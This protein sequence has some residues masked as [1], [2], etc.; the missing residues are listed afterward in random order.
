MLSKYFKCWSQ[1]EIVMIILM[2][3]KCLSFVS[4]TKAE[5]V[6]FC[7]LL[8]FFE[9]ASAS[10]ECLLVYTWDIGT[11]SSLVLTCL[12]IASLALLYRFEAKLA[13]TDSNINCLMRLGFKHGLVFQSFVIFRSFN[14]VS[15]SYLEH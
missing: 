12:S 14:L 5:L 9:W 11:V 2:K 4:F 15:Q 6:F 10:S 1:N 3:W 13:I 7:F 8:Q